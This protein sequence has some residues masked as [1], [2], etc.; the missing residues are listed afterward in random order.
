[1]HLRC[2]RWGKLLF[3]NHTQCHTRTILI[4]LFKTQ[5]SVECCSIGD[6]RDIGCAEVQYRRHRGCSYCPDEE[7]ISGASI[8]MARW[9]SAVRT[10]RTRKY[11]VDIV[12]A[13]CNHYVWTI[14]LL[15]T[16]LSS[17]PQEIS[18]TAQ[19]NH[20]LKRSPLLH[21]CNHRLKRSQLLHITRT[22]ESRELRYC[23]L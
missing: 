11:T 16:V 4:L 23:T 18:T 5:Y 20:R 6:V 7:D 14:P 3:L 2:R 8:C 21:N 15:H 17:P 10:V 12:F 9:C 22:Q 13:H 1:M 19:C